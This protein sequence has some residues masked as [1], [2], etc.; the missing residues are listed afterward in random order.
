MEKLSDIIEILLNINYCTEFIPLIICLVFVKKLKANSLKVFFVYTIVST[1]FV[2]LSLIAQR[3]FNSYYFT[4]LSI[5]FF[6][7]LEFI[8]ICIFYRTVFKNSKVKNMLIFASFFFLAFC[9]YSFIKIPKLE[10]D[11][12]PL[13]V[14]CL[15]FTI[16][17]LYYFYETMR[18]NFSTPLFQVPTFWFSVAFLIY[19]SGNFFL[20]LFSKS[21]EKEPGFSNQYYFIVSTITIIKNILFCTAL[22]VN[23][24]LII[25]KS[26]TSIPSNLN[27][28]NFE[29]FSKQNNH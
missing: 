16:V 5:Q 13:V 11:F 18:L 4:L 25:Q 20:F 8:L 6:Q 7:A 23:K 24:N 3:Y 9:I 22:F 14:E 28:D 10:F 1:V 26:N 29:S 17:V 19:F 2:S 12:M 21:M 27:L 15:F